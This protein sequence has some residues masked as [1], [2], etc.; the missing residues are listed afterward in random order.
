[1]ISAFTKYSG[2]TIF[3]ALSTDEAPTPDNTEYPK[4]KNG[5][6]LILIDKDSDNEF[7]FDG[8][9]NSWLDNSDNGGDEAML[10]TFTYDQG[11]VSAD[12]S[13]DEINSAIA[14]GK[15]V[16]GI[17]ELQSV[18]E[19]VLTPCNIVSALHAVRFSS[20]FISGDKIRHYTV[21]GIVEQ[22]ED[23]WQITPVN[24]QAEVG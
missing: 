9:T 8:S 15:F 14:E 18:G 2:I 5:D 23:G 4:P 11:A 24:L 20:T 13:I 21:D 12:K 7:Y 10:V 19:V 22:G 1:M 3:M 6:K 17:I 16:Y